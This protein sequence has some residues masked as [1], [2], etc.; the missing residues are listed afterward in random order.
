MSI[1]DLRLSFW[2]LDR[3]STRRRGPRRQRRGQLG[4]ETLEVRLV[5]TTSTW[6]GTVDGNWTTAGNWQPAPPAAGDDLAFPSTSSNLTNNN[7]IGSGIAYGALLIQGANY[8]IG[9]DSASFNSID[10]SQASGTSNVSLQ[11]DL[12][13]A[14]TVGVDNAASTLVLGGAITGSA[15][16]TK[17][18]PG[19][20]SLTAANSYTNATAINA[21]TLLLVNGNLGTSPVTVA[22]GATLGGVGTVDSISAAGATVSPGNSAAGVLIDNGALSLGADAS[23]NK[24]NYSLVIDGPNPGTGAHFYGQ[25][26]VGGAINLTA[27]TLSVTLGSDFT[28]SVGTSYTIIE[29]T[30]SH[31]VNGIFNGLMQG[32]TFTVSGVTFEVIYNGGA[33]AN[34]VVLDEVN[35][36][37]TTLSVSDLS[38][39]YGQSVALTANVSGSPNPGTPTGSVD[40]FQGTTL[41]GTVTLTAGS[42]TL[43]TSALVVGASSITAKYVGNADFAPSTS[44]ATTVTVAQATTSTAV[45]FLPSSPALGQSV[46]LTATITPTTTGTTA[47]TGTVNFLDGTVVLG[48]GKVVNNLA[49]FSTSTLPEGS[50]SSTA[51]YTGDANYTTSTSP[52]TTVTISA[53]STTTTVNYSPALPVVGQQV[54]LTATITPGSAFSPL[55]TGTVDFFNGSTLLG[56]ATVSNDVATFNTT[57]LVVGNNSVTAQYLGD[58]NY[59]GSTSAVNL[60][61]IVL[62]ATTTTL[63]PLPNTRLTPFEN[64][65]LTATVAIVSPGAGTLSGHVTFFANG[66]S[67]GTANVSGGKATLSVALP[68]AN[69][70]ITAQYSNDPNFQSSTSTAVTAVVGTRNQQWLNSVSFLELN[71]APT[72]AELARWSGLLDHGVSRKQVTNAISLTPEAKTLALQNLFTDILG[73]PGTPKAY[74]GTTG[75]AKTTRTSHTAVLLGSGDFFNLSGGTLSTYLAAIETAAIGFAIEQ[76]HIQNQLEKG[77]LPTKVAEEIVQNK[78][79]WQQ[80]ITTTSENVLGIVPTTGELN[81]FVQKLSQGILLRQILNSVLASNQFFK[82]ATSPPS[83]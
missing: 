32:A 7:N 27:A 18:G 61:A 31:T 67:L 68:I 37:T 58:A 36:S 82:S 40:F 79:A 70:S 49:T 60:A 25:T 72:R 44:T 10:A 23:S 39:T 17:N 81:F 12:T 29:N 53:I 71:R 43:N 5:P 54:T 33:N 78:L 1:L 48:N 83:S 69:D 30:G 11:I 41:L 19:T 35:P 63:A 56:S 75:A 38:P 4:L 34:S 55:P 14:A 62:A 80:L 21:G 24:S 6:L 8:A 26:Q 59:A 57:A 22:S 16:L 20:L 46:T 9:G 42:A 45:T 50:H 74:A 13:G 3:A 73:T 76:P 64:V 51:E 28:P 52:A 66:T 15:G 65:T 47:P 77:V 2:R